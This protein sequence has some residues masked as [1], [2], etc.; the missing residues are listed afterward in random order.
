MQCAFFRIDAMVAQRKSKLLH[1]AEE[2]SRRAAFCLGHAVVAFVSDVTGPDDAGD[3]IGGLFHVHE[4]RVHHERRY[5]D[6]DK[7]AG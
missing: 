5:T 6:R 2:M 1:T 4:R 3:G 7:L